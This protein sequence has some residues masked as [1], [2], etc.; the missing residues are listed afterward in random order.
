MKRAK[1]RNSAGFLTKCARIR[2]KK[3][4]KKQRTEYFVTNFSRLEIINR[5]SGSVE[6]FKLPLHTHRHHWIRFSSLR[7]LLKMANDGSFFF[8][9]FFACCIIVDDRRENKKKFSRKFIQN[10]F[11]FF[12][13]SH[14]KLC[15]LA[16]ARWICE[17]AS[18]RFKCWK[19]TFIC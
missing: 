17:A 14:E 9:S 12:A 18:M 19:K 1:E 10:W 3:K 13:Y 8:F 16:E 6:R 2:V 7:R 11:F 15:S 5:P 4:K